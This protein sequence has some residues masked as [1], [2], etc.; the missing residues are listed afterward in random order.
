[1]TKWLGWCVFL[2]IIAG[3]LFY[4]P[5]MSGETGYILIS[6]GN[7]TFSGSLVGFVSATILALLVIWL[8]TVLV[9]LTFRLI[10][11]PSAWWQRRQKSNQA[12]FLQNGIDFMALGQWQQAKQQFAKVKRRERL[13]TAKQ[14][15]FVCDAHLAEQLTEEIPLDDSDNEHSVFSKL[16]VLAKQQRFDEALN[17][18]KQLNKAL[19]KYPIALQQLVLV[20]YARNFDW[21]QLSKWLPKLDK[22]LAKA[23][24]AEAIENWK[25]SLAD[26]VDKAFDDFILAHSV[27]QLQAIWNSWP[28]QVQQHD[29]IFSAYSGVLARHQQTHLVEALLLQDKSMK[30]QEQT[31]EVIRLLFNNAGIVQ[32]DKL[33]TQ[34][35]QMAS[36]H[37]ENKVLLTVYAYLAAGHKDYQLAKQAL[38]QSLYS[39]DNVTDKKLYAYVLSELGELRRSIET[40]KSL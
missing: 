9:K 29:S 32:M 33:F 14:L 6:L 17:L 22:Q 35:Q 12:N 39:Q 2:V 3:L 23:Q 27:N 5:Q 31:L 37:P 30:R 8:V 16:M 4:A 25:L 40:F 21:N 7:Q 24:D 19:P 11:L 36:K 15:T 34:V 38:E 26:S 18:V 13:D 28:R 10:V 20:I 1:M